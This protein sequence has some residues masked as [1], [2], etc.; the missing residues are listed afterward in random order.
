MEFRE[1]GKVPAEPTA[2]GA[3]LAEMHK[4]S[5]SPIEKFGF[6]TVTCYSRILQDVD[7]WDESWCAVFSRHL[8]LFVEHGNKVLN[9]PEWDVVAACILDKVVP[10]LLVP[11]QEDGRTIKPCLCHGD[12][13]DGNT[14]MDRLTGKAM[15]FDVCTFYAH[16]EYDIGNWRAPRHRLSEEAYLKAY[17]QSYKMSEPGMAAIPAT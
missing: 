3:T 14:A 8:G 6:H 15:I 17:K 4:T 9:W 13:W 12:C 2:L 5:Q 7:Y 16:N 1:F 10:R 11:L